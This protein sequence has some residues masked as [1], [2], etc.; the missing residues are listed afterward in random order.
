MRDGP[1]LRFSEAQP[2]AHHRRLA[3]IVALACA[4]L[5]LALVPFARV[6][7]AEFPAF[8]AAYQSALV[9][10]DLITASIILNQYA[11]VRSGALALL[12]GAYVFTA[13]MAFLHA[14]TFPG[15]LAPRG[16]L[17]AGEQTTAW[18]YIFWHGGFALFIVGYAVLKGRR[19]ALS[20]AGAVALA[21]TAAAAAMLVTTAGHDALPRIMRGNHY[22]GITVIALGLAWVLSALAALVLWLRRPHSVLDLWLIVTMVAWIGEVGLA[23]VFNQGR[24]DFG[25]YV[26]RLYGLL[27]LSVLLMVF[28]N[29]Y[30]LLHARSA[31]AETEARSEA[32][33]RTMVDA[34]P[35]LAWMARADG[36]IYWYNRRWYE[37]TG[38]S[39]AQMEGW[40]WQSV[41]DPRVLPDVL[42][43][44]KRSIASGEPFDMI[45]PLR[46]A[47]GV[48]RPFLTRIS[49]VKDPSGKVV[50]WFGTNTDITS[51]RDAEDALRRA[52]RRKD[53][54]LATLAHE[55]RN[56]LA[57]IRNSVALLQRLALPAAAELPRDII[58]RQSR[59]LARLVDDLLEVSRITRGKLE[60][61]KEHV[62]LQRALADALESVKPQMERLR[63]ELTVDLA[64]EPLTIEADATRITQIFVNLLHNAAKF[65]PQSGRIALTA[66][67]QGDWAAVTVRDN[68]VG[69]PAEHVPRLFDSF[70]QVT[71][72]LER[73]TGG[74]GIGLALVRGLVDL[75]G[76]RVEARSAGPGLGSE[77]TVHLPLVHALAAAARRAPDDNPVLAAQR[78]RVLVVDDNTDTAESLRRLIEM[79]GHDAM[80]AHDGV[81]AVRACRAFAPDV[82]LLDIGMP[83]MNGY[84]AARAIRREATR[85]PTLIAITGWGQAQ[86]KQ[87]AREAGFD[88]H[89]TK[90]VGLAVLQSVLD[91]QSKAARPS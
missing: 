61:H 75:H 50:H 16:A 12:G 47:D 58:D 85:T 66:A 15:L 32:R 8:I 90:P 62:P 11:I 89:F 36:W 91:D 23:A 70:S 21:I 80:E 84:D 33:F 72:A 1:L 64:R 63:H 43:R 29:E 74:L 7:L 55:L 4:V 3:A 57:P 39:P 10:I 51:Q 83:R 19:L 59:H 14:L 76:G 6:P 86:D 24:F 9:I 22:T 13:A 31:A 44:W 87:R 2:T 35:Q 26:G 73:S 45:F 56:P 53:E 69:I 82:V 71:P 60:L 41:H 46:G 20:P 27:A 54:F 37:Y 5:F 79:L 42:D 67:R 38:T 49:P 68:G 18:M 17:G 48:F 88:G 77:F 78:K 34:I 81:E 25:F 65:T 40:G 52:D 30:W 28:L